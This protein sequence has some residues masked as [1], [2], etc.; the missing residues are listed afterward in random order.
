[1][2]LCALAPPLRVLRTYSFAHLSQPN[3]CPGELRA[4][5]RKAEWNDHDG[6]AGRHYHDDTNNKDGTAEGQY[7]D[8]SRHSIG[9]FRW[10]FHR[11]SVPRD[12]SVFFVARYRSL[13]RMRPTLTLSLIAT[14]SSIATASEPVHNIELTVDVPIVTV[15]PRQPGRITMRLPSVTFSVTVAVD[16]GADWQPDS[17]SISVADSGASLNA[18]QLQAGRELTF[19]LHIPSSQIAPLRIERYCID[20][21]AD[22]ANAAYQNRITIPGVMSAQASLRC[23]TE[24]ERSTT[25]VTKPLDIVLECAAPLPAKN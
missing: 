9:D 14:V 5:N 20:D 6:R 19:D 16:C 8:S 7:C 23:A 4:E 15:T 24:S 2:M 1:M 21:E 25:Y 3:F 17:V 13:G 12:D 11:A 10:V 22:A 18:E